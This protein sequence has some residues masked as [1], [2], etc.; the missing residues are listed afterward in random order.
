MPGEQGGPLRGVEPLLEFREQLRMSERAVQVDKEPGDPALVERRSKGSPQGEGQ[1]Q[2]SV[3]AT[4]V[5]S[6][7]LAGCPTLKEGAVARRHPGTSVLA[8][9]QEHATGHG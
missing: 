3:I 2:R 9:Q 1:S 6:E 4:P 5:S 8:G 7:R